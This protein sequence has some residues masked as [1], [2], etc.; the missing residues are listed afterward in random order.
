[1][2]SVFTR[3]PIA[4]TPRGRAMGLLPDGCTCARNAGNV[5]PATDFIGNRWL[6]GSRHA[7]RHVRHA[8]VLM[9][10]GIANPW[11]RGKH[12]RHSWCMR[13]PQFYVSGKRPMGHMLW[14]KSLIFAL[15]QSLLYWTHITKYSSSNHAPLTPWGRDKMDA[16]FQTTFFKWIFLGT[17]LTTFQH[18]YR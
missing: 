7:S 14:V 18:W 16:I 1:M 8:R 9:H 13:N 17:Q 2:L 12:S 3:T 10:V 15:P 4:D 11:W 5:F 6:S